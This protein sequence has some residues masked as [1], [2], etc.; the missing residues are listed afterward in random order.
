MTTQ[1]EYTRLVAELFDGITVTLRKKN[2]DYTGASGDPFANFRLSELEGV[3]PRT[4]VMI[5][6]QDK[7]QRL[8]TAIKRGHLQVD[9]EGWQD[10][11]KDII[12]YMTLL[13]GLFEEQE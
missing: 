2:H 13:Y 6:V 9:N 11:I 5:R 10:A 3:D 8:R 12:G 4:G 7:M 1:E